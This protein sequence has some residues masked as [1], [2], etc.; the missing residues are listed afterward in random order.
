MVVLEFVWKERGRCLNPQVCE[1]VSKALEVEGL[2]TSGSS[3]PLGPSLTLDGV[4]V[5]GTVRAV[6]L[7]A[8]QGF[9]GVTPA[10]LLGYVVRSFGLNES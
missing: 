8:E 6:G 4:E 5:L 9:P 10:S 3:S 1:S 2:A 7:M